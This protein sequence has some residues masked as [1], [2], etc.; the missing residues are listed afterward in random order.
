MRPSKLFGPQSE[1]AARARLAEEFPTV[2]GRVID[3]VL[4]AYRRETPTL[5]QAFLAAHD[6]IEDA[7]ATSAF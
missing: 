3:Q 2:P 5:K 7:R 6:R 4:S 1:Q